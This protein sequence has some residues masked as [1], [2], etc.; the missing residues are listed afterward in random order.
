M[1]VIAM[2]SGPCAAEALTAR[3]S[4]FSHEF[5]WLER[6]S[7]LATSYKECRFLSKWEKLSLAPRRFEMCYKAL[8]VKE[9]WPIACYRTFPPVRPRWSPASFPHHGAWWPCCYIP[10]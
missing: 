8:P 6:L 4:V 5:N 1:R 3:G 10:T 9:I 7:K 2:F